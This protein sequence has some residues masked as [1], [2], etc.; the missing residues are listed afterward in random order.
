[1][2]SDI[3]RASLLGQCRSH[4]ARPCPQESV[5]DLRGIRCPTQARIL[6]LSMTASGFRKRRS[7]AAFETLIQN[8]ISLT[9]PTAPRRR[10]ILRVPMELGLMSQSNKPDN[11]DKPKPVRRTT[12]TLG[13]PNRALTVNRSKI[14]SRTDGKVIK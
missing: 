8:Q 6:G 3:L 14:G 2:M 10:P 5:A 7:A 13:L 9:I 1:M 12:P 11:V 4:S